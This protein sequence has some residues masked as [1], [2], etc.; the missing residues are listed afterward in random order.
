MPK[1]NW[2]SK[3]INKIRKLELYIKTEN[4]IIVW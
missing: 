3:Y 1:Q 4:E 2:H